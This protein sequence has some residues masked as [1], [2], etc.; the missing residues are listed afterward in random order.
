MEM[1]TEGIV[2]SVPPYVSVWWDGEGGHGVHREP[3][4]HELLV[5]MNL[6]I[7]TMKC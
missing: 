7:F 4:V 5:G 1:V 3:Y 2:V 6:V